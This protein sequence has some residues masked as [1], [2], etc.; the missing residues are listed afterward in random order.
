MNKLYNIIIRYLKTKYNYYDT[1]RRLNKGERLVA[2][3]KFNSLVCDCEECII[4]HNIMLL[5][6]TIDIKSETEEK[7][8]VNLKYRY[9]IG[10]IDDDFVND[11]FTLK[12]ELTKC[13]DKYKELEYYE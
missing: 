13:E 5:N 8:N 6:T 9:S 1:R 2:S 12:V 10:Y 3:V 7:Y 11:L 4:E